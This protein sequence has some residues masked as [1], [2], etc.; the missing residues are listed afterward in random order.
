[1]PFINWSEDLR[2]GLDGIDREHRELLSLLNALHDALQMNKRAE[3]IG[4]LLDELISGTVA[5]FAHEEECMAAAQYPGLREHKR[6][7][8]A[9]RVQLMDF[10]MKTANGVTQEMSR[11][12][13]IFLKC[14]MFVHIFSC[15]RA[16]APYLCAHGAGLDVRAPL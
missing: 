5:H 9:I 15:D 4:R 6:E 12:L 16:F 10:Y 1:M 2:L 3:A 8:D 7:H 13:L 11:D 14:W